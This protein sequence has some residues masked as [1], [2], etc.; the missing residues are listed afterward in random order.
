MPEHGGAASLRLMGDRRRKSCTIVACNDEVAIIL[1]HNALHISDVYQGI[2]GA[3]H[4]F[5]VAGSIFIYAN[6]EKFRFR[7]FDLRSDAGIG[8]VVRHT[9]LYVISIIMIFIGCFA[10]G[11]VY[12]HVV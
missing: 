9:P 10:F 5:N 3:P 11:A 2:D 12:L 8:E 6:S 7:R 4:D 1:A